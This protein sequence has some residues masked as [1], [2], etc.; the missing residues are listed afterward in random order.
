MFYKDEE[1]YIKFPF[2]LLDK[3]EYLATL[4]NRLTEF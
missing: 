4:S 3:S 2:N 1:L